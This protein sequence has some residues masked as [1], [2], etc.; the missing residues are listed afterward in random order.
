MHTPSSK[1]LPKRLYVLSVCQIELIKTFEKSK[2]GCFNI[3][4]KIVH[5]IPPKLISLIYIIHVHFIA[6]YSV[7]QRMS[8]LC[9]LVSEKYFLLIKFKLN[10]CAA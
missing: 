7:R 9:L 8:N 1:V 4:L 6:V 2:F 5:Q 3:N 10:Y